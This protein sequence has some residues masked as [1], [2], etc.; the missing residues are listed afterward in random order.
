M[1]TQRLLVCVGLILGLGAG[2]AA[3]QEDETAEEPAWKGSLGLSYLATSGNSDT[4]TFGL[5][6]KAERRPEPWGLEVI[7]AFNRGE[8]NRILTAER[9][10]LSGRGKRALGERWEYFAGLSGEQDEFAGFTLRALIETGLVY[11][12]RL[13]PTHKL[14]VDGGL[15][16]TD[17]NRVEPEPDVDF[18]GGVAGV[19]YEWTISETASLTQRL[20]YYPNFDDTSDWRL[21]S[22]TA[23]QAAI[24]SRFAVKFGYELRYRNQPIGDSDDTDTT[25]KASLVWSF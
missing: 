21:T 22:D 23:V 17:E 16:W 14:S 13:G 8:E 25:T 2:W 7:G 20:V 11:K 9:Y 3:A 18:L 4:Q 5:D 6:F 19:A 10:Y 12:V 1:N 24:S 15:A